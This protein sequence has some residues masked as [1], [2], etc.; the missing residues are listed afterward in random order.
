MCWGSPNTRRTNLRPPHSNRNDNK[1]LIDI[2][3]NR[4][5][6]DMKAV[7]NVPE[8]YFNMVVVVVQGSTCIPLY[9]F[10]FLMVAVSFLMVGDDWVL[11][12]FTVGESTTVTPSSADP[13]SEDAVTEGMLCLQTACESS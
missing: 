4:I 2:V 5:S 6:R 8:I 1:L 13:S 3:W 10:S 9:A 11:P 12:F 7:V